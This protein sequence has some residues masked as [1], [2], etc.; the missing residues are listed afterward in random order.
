M[1]FVDI[2][3]FGIGIYTRACGHVHGEPAYSLLGGGFWMV[4]WFKIYQALMDQ[5]DE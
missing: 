1:A 5:G 3:V 4:M 2:W